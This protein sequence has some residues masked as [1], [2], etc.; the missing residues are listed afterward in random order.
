MSNIT[1]GDKAAKEFATLM[2]KLKNSVETCKSDT[3]ELST[4]IMAITGRTLVDGLIDIAKN[5]N[6]I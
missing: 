4:K 1:D 6:V 3:P 5:K 2:K